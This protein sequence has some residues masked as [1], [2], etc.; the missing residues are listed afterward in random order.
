MWADSSMKSD[1]PDGVHRV[2]HGTL[3][4]RASLELRDRFLRRELGLRLSETDVAGEESQMH[5]V[6][7]EGE[8][9]IGSVIAKPL[10]GKTC[11]IRQMVVEEDQRGSGAGIS[12]MTA[13]EETMRSLGMSCVV[14]HSRDYAVGFYERCGYETTSGKFHEL[15]IVHYRMEKTL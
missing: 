14:L 8:R 6:C 5:F 15:G 1:L 7:V 4:Y 10:D 13:A 12:L 9:V 11:R 2:E 3:E